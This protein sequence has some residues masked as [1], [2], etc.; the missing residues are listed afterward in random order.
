MI[1][2]S[3]N[4]L[5][6][7]LIFLFCGIILGVINI[8]LEIIFTLKYAK[9]IKNIVFYSIFYIFFAIIF[10]F[11]LNFFN[12]GLFSTTLLLSI[13]LGFVWIK[14]V[15]KNLVVF[16]INKWYNIISKNKKE[17]KCKQNKKKLKH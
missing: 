4:Q 15:S 1:F 8:V 9:K 16:L 12:F 6:N 10:I 13:I 3:F 2:Y 14:Y 17:P 7:F 5:N 11:L